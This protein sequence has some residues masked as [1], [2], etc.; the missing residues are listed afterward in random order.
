MNLPVYKGNWVPF[1]HGPLTGDVQEEAASASFTRC[2]A[3]IVAR[4]VP[5][6]EH[7][8]V[9]PHHPKS[10]CTPFF[11][12]GDGERR[13]RHCETAVSEG[14]CCFLELKWQEKSCREMTGL[15]CSVI[16]QSR[17]WRW[18]GS[19]LCRALQLIFLWFCQIKAS[20]GAFPSLRPCFSPRGC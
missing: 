2:D 4:R 18:A 5:C 12:G 8:V 17:N 1:G 3:E 7:P 19:P 6:S 10:C 14:G 9:H 15:I 20:A 11:S 13:P 16:N